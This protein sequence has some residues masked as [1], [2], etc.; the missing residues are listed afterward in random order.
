MDFN[1]MNETN[2]TFKMDYNI[3]ISPMFY[4]R[5]YYQ[6]VMCPIGIIGN[7][8]SLLIFIRVNR[9]RKNNTSF[10]YS[11][12]CVLNILLTI[13]SNFIRKN[14]ASLIYSYNIELPI[15]QLETFIRL[16][17]FD[18]ITWMQVLIS[19]DRFILIVFP[20]K[21]KLISKEVISL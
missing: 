18:S 6:Q 2:F 17:L 13:E 14:S 5:K 7:F 12:L 19:F 16:A 11:V 15:C 9:K 1:R 3:N 20:S 10:L 21:A 8:I 4:V